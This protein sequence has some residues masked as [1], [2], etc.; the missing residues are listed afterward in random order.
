[1]H[2]LRET[3]N[4]LVVRCQIS[5]KTSNNNAKA[6]FCSH[7]YQRWTIEISLMSETSNFMFTRLMTTNNVVCLLAGIFC[8]INRSGYGEYRKMDG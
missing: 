3:I 5:E 7:I 8:F 4:C 6:F 1:M 2:I